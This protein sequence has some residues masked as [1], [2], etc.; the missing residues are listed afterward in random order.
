MSRF[1][2]SITWVLAVLACAGA[3]APSVGAVSGPPPGD[4]PATVES[5]ELAARLDTIVRAQTLGQFWGSVL[6]ADRGGIV[7]ARGYGLADQSLE[8]ITPGSLFD[9]GS[10]SKA[11]TAAAVL[12]LEMEGRLRL[13]ATINQYLDGVPDHAT[14]IT[15]GHLLGHTSGVAA[16]DGRREDSADGVI[17]AVLHQPPKFAPGSAMEYSNAGYFLLAALIEKVSGVAYEQFVV[18]QV[19]GP[20]GMTSSTMIGLPVPHATEPHVTARV[21]DQS[22][23]RGRATSQPYAYAW[24]Y[25]GAGGVVASADDLLRFDRALRSDELLDRAARDRMFTPGP[26]GYGLGWFV[27]AGPRG[28]RHEHSGG[29]WGYAS[30]MIRHEDGTVVIVLTNGRTDPVRL[31][32]LLEAAVIPEMSNQLDVRLHV[33]GET[34]DDHG[35]I[36]TAATISTIRNEGGGWNVL[37]EDAGRPGTPL[38]SIALPRRAAADVAGQLET[39]AAGATAQ[40]GPVGCNLWLATMRYTQRADGTI[41]LPDDVSIRVQ[42]GFSS[43]DGKGKQFRD[44]RVTL[45]VHDEANS[46]WPVILMLDEA[47]RRRLHAELAAAK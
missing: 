20:A 12:R 23:R 33:A 21:D 47:T 10:I 4:A 43:S 38:V 14:A 28:W 34:L 40:D 7:L 11:F 41:Q 25:K 13:D 30:E 15:I 45:I 1:S 17:R 35:M 8:P 44:G 16:A 31:A 32:S 29:V 2:S 5:G 9:I 19:L 18:D 22:T 36:R 39:A 37:I 27:S 42:P 26:G 6:V 3:T 24:G 46:F